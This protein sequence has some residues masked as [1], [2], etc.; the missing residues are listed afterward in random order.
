MLRAIIPSRPVSRGRLISARDFTAR[1]ID[2]L[3]GDPRVG[4]G[5]EEGASCG[6]SE[7][8]RRTLIALLGRIAEH[9]GLTHGIHPAYRKF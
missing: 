2:G 4:I 3:A 5:G 7:E 1:D 9:Q 6:L 8:E